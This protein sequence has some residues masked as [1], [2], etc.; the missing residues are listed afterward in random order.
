MAEKSCINED[1]RWIAYWW[2]YDDGTTGAALLDMRNKKGERLLYAEMLDTRAELD[3][4]LDK[5]RQR[6]EEAGCTLKKKKLNLH[7]GVKYFRK[8]DKPKQSKKRGAYGWQ[9]L[10]RFLNSCG[11]GEDNRREVLCLFSSILSGYYARLVSPVIQKKYPVVLQ[12]CAPTVLINGA[13]AT[14]DF[15]MQTIRALGIYTD[16]DCAK[17]K[18]KHTRIFPYSMTQRS[19]MDCAFLYTKYDKKK[20]HRFPTQYRDTAVLI[21]GRHFSGKEIRSFVRRNRWVSCVL[22]DAPAKSSGM[23]PVKLRASWL[24]CTDYSWDVKGIHYLAE[25]FVCFLANLQDREDCR[26]KLKQ[27][28]GNI[29][30]CLIRYN[31]QEG[32]QRPTP[33][34]TYILSLQLL[35]L[36]LFFAILPRG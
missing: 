27:W 36:D 4:V 9:E 10:D 2:K 15:L 11:A 20:K 35:T 31:A 6:C 21:H 25:R 30:D 23:L 34:K 18:R 5:W 17:L 29:E 8:H 3:T 19:F 13:N 33:T 7:S 28:L 22:L 14:F 26:K 16:Y 32:I 1:K 12:E 24:S